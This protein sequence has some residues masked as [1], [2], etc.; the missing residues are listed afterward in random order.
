MSQNPTVNAN[1]DKR[2]FNPVSNISLEPYDQK[3]KDDLLTIFFMNSKGSW[4]VKSTCI[5]KNEWM[6]ALY[7]DRKNNRK[8]H[9]LLFLLLLL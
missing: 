4:N 6:D 5:T 1:I 3:D 2:C 9:F 7:S 8:N